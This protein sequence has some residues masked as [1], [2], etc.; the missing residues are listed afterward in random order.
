VNGT[1]HDAVKLQRPSNTNPSIL[2]QSPVALGR[3]RF[4]QSVQVA[5]ARLTCVGSRLS[6]AN[7]TRDTH[8]GLALPV[9]DAA[10]TDV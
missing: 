4:I 7:H 1:G 10:A 9:T 8:V 5:P 2:S 3:S 6:A